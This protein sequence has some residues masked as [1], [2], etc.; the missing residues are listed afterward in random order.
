M[1]TSD[2]EGH[3]WASPIRGVLTTW[4]WDGIVEPLT[5]ERDFHRTGSVSLGVTGRW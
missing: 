2:P 1:I 5:G 4:L 3:L